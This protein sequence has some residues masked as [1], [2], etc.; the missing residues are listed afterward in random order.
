MLLH[1]NLHVYGAS[2]LDSLETSGLDTLETS[3]IDSLETSGLDR[4]LVVYPTSRGGGESWKT[5]NNSF[6]TNSP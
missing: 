5:L 3:E 4:Q 6:I 2:G 1:F